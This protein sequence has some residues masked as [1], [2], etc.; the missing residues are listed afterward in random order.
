MAETV[1]NLPAMQERQVRSLGQEDTLEKEMASH[2]S[3]LVGR[4]SWT[5]EP[6]GLRS[7]GPQR[8]GQG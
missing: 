8:S 1:K 7:M 5:E 6:D 2:S 3:I 4:I